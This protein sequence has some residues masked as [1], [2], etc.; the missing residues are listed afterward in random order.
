MSNRC[1]LLLITSSALLIF[2]APQARAQ[3]IGYPSVAAALDALKSRSDVSI[4]NQ[5]GWIII[6]ERK[7][8]ALWSFTPAGH[9]AHPAVV[10]RGLVEKNGNISIEMTALCQAS[11]AACDKLIEEFKNL[12]AQIGQSVRAKTQGPALDADSK[13]EVE[14]I[15]GESFR[16]V[17]TSKRSVSV[18]AGQIELMS[19]ANE[20]CAPRIADFGKYQFE[21]SEPLDVASGARSMFVL[22]QEIRCGIE[23]SVS[24]N[25]AQG[26]SPPQILPNAS[27]DQRA[28]SETLAYFALRDKAHY[29]EAYASMSLER[30]K[31]TSLER[32][33]ELISK[34]NLQAGDVISR[35]IK[36]ITWYRDP[37]GSPLGNYAAVD[38]LSEFK[39]VPY[40]CGYVVW[41]E[42]AQ[43]FRL[44]RE[45]ENIIDADTVKKLAPDKLEELIARFKCK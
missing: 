34:F 28:E 25:T 17:L 35:K 41:R 43:E 19:K 39:N 6:D 5:G 18:D 24:A 10:K 31:S 7:T 22:R 40:H 38:Y 12:N 29:K 27:R 23:N 14:K 33:T 26:S 32:W 2:A 11:K 21:L 8:K 15:D 3:G 45:E 42:S 16:L 9:P 20:L 44:V 30:Q 13:I 1:L 4:S 37:P 36:K